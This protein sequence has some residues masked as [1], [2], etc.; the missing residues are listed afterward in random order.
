M[1]FL[2]SKIKH[3][4]YIVKENLTFDQ[5]LGDLGNGSNG[6]PS[7]ALFG[8]RVTPVSTAWRTTS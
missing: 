8:K 2:H 4:I 1:N 7:L 6:D 5:I 3:I